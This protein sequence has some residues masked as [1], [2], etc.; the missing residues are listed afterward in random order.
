MPLRNVELVLNGAPH[1]LR[2]DF[3]ALA[4]LEDRGDSFDQ[5]LR[6][7]QKDDG[8]VSMKAIVSLV[9]AA[10]DHEEPRPSWR[11]VSRW[12]DGW[13]AR[14]VVQAIDQAALSAF[15]PAQDNGHGP[16]PVA[17][18]AGIGTVSGASPTVPASSSPPSSGG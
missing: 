2:F 13:N 11:E 7:Q 9:W 14:D 3:G 5:L 8:R 15:P 1:R 16:P 17:P 18:E 6:L 12:I 10:L 4:A